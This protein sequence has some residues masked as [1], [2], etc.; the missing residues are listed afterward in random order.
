MTEGSQ[1]AV[2]M[3]MFC[4][5]RQKCWEDKPDEEL[6]LEWVK[7]DYDDYVLDDAIDFDYVLDESKR[8]KDAVQP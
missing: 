6:V 4:G 2:M 5:N 1:R 3:C 8:R 7:C